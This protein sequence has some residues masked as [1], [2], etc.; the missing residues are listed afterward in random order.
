[1]SISRN[2]PIMRSRRGRWRCIT[3]GARRMH[4]CGRSI[5]KT[6]SMFLARFAMSL[7]LKDG[8]WAW[9]ISHHGRIKCEIA[10]TDA[11]NG[12]NHVDME[13][14]RQ[15]QG[16]MGARSECSGS[17]E[18]VPA[19][20]PHPR[21]AAAKVPMAC[22]GRIPIRSPGRLP[23]TICACASKRPRRRR[24]SASRIS[25]R[26]SGPAASNSPVDELRYGQEWASK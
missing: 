2:F 25:L 19:E 21:A 9:V 5:R 3:P 18:R 7:G 23:G 11:V 24:R 14:H 20:P 8:D 4:G 1:M 22:A 6:R 16:R 13:C 17:D 10:R 26:S 15:A 12:Q